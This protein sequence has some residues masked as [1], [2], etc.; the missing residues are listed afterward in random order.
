MNYKKILEQ[1]GLVEGVDFSITL[2]GFEKI[3]KTKLVDQEIIHEAT[4]AKMNGETVIE[5]AIPSYVE[6]VQIEET[7][8]A[9]FP[10]EAEILNAHKNISISEIDIV[11]L[12]NEYLKDKKELQD[13]E[14]DSLNIVDGQ[15]YS[16]N[17]KNIPC[18]TR[19][20]LYD[21]VATVKSNNNKE[22]KLK[23]ILELEAQITQRRIREAILTNDNSFIININNQ[24]ELL[25][26]SL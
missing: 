11:I 13:S 20:Q 10:S 19:D 2:N 12:I 24:I 25:R 4:P 9:N 7:Y 26:G 6:T 8:Y 16:W 21:L 5:P 15:I 17:F 14:S 22:A 3:A 1:Y 23:Q 18:P